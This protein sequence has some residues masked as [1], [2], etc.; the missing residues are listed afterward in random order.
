[1]EVD[2]ASE[3]LAGLRARGIAT[4]VVSNADGRVEA[5]LG[6]LGLAPHLEVVLDSH[7]EGVEKPDPEIFRRALARL[8]RP[9]ARTL[10]VGDI[11]SIDALGARAAGLTPVLLDP[12][13]GYA[14]A[15]CATIARLPELLGQSSR[16][17]PQAFQ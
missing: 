4:G 15:D 12:L 13:G 3:T 1:M 7:L 6:A 11:Y 2:A 9:A 14:D 8:D 10:Y 17:R 5:M 16:L